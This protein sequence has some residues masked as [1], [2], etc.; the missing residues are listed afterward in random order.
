MLI[1]AEE[2]E[3]FNKSSIPDDS[4]GDEQLC[5]IILSNINE[6]LSSPSDPHQSEQYIPT[7]IEVYKS[8]NYFLIY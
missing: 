5:S 3:H 7:E 6:S 2:D 8:V 4:N 1:L